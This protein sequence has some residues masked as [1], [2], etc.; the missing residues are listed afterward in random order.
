MRIRTGALAFLLAVGLG[1]C[2]SKSG[3]SGIEGAWRVD[4]EPTVTAAIELQ[5]RQG[6]EK[7]EKA[8]ADLKKAEEE[9]KSLP[10]AERKSKLASKRFE[11]TPFGYAKAFKVWETS[12]EEGAKVLEED[13]KKGAERLRRSSIAMGL[14]ADRRYVGR[15]ELPHATDVEVGTYTYEGGKLTT[16]AEARNGVPE[17]KARPHTYDAKLEGDRLTLTTEG[18]ILIFR[19]ADGA[20]SATLDPR[21]LKPC[22]MITPE[23]LTA[24][25]GFAVGAGKPSGG[26]ESCD[27]PLASDP[28]KTAVTIIFNRDPAK[29]VD[30][31][32]R[33]T[34]SQPVADVGDEAYAF[35][36]TVNARKGTVTVYVNVSSLA[37]RPL[38]GSAAKIAKTLLD[39]VK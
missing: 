27:F 32:N 29:S 20:V 13:T 2:G 16:T 12:P 24:A 30:F 37:A 10:E 19:R 38:A 4:I 5:V 7:I 11:L 1:A 18:M 6:R 23:E 22:E 34:G 33:F 9:V 31:K 3:G 25:L 36:E 21:R 8:L 14:G 28:T 35:G 26:S 17:G 15:T 39:R